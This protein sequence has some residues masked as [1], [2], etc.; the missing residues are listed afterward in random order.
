[1]AIYQSASLGQRVKLPLTPLDPFYTRQGALANAPHF[2]AKTSSVENFTDNNIT[3][4]R[5]FNSKQV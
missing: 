2:H 5:D 3:F 4:G 1:M